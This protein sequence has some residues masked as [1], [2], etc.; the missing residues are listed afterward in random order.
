MAQFKGQKQGL[1]IIMTLAVLAL[2]TVILLLCYFY[3]SFARADAALN[4]VRFGCWLL[5]A[6]V[7]LLLAALVIFRRR[8]MRERINDNKVV[9]PQ[10][11]DGL[12]GVLAKQSFTTLVDSILAERRGGVM[13][14]LDLDNFKAVND[15]WGHL[16][17]DRVLACFGAV[18]NSLAIGQVLCGRVGGDEFALFIAEEN[19]PA[20]GELLAARLQQRWRQCGALPAVSVSIGIAATD[21]GSFDQLF[22]AA[23]QAMYRAKR[24]GRNCYAS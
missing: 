15:Q 11:R 21:C 13:L 9:L 20:A 18:L 24:Q 5:L 22:A 23:D 16:T 8:I 1:R 19:Q 14:M 2:A 4:L 6:V 3:L 10:L 17:G 12:T 7:G